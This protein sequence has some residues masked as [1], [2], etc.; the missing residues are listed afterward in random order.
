MWNRGDAYLQHFGC[1]LESNSACLAGLEIDSFES[2]QLFYRAGRTTHKIT[3]VEL[4]NFSA[5]ECSGIGNVYRSVS[6]SAILHCIT[7]LF[8]LFLFHQLHF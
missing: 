5:G 7:Y 2:F 1:Y 8:C 4:Y 6:V 3:D